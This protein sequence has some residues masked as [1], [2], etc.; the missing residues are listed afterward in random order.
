MS[1]RISPTASRKAAGG[2]SVPRSCTVKP[3][4]RASTLKMSLPMK[5]MSPST[6]PSTMVPSEGP[7]GD[8]SPSR[9]S[10][11]WLTWRMISPAMIRPEMK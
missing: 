3:C 4:T 9:G 5:C 1:G 2:T 8:S 11:C 7:A 6:V 10:T